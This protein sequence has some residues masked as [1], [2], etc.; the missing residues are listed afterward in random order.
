VESTEPVNET[1][2]P[3][4]SDARTRWFA[5]APVTDG[6]VTAAGVSTA[7]LEG[8]A[9]PPIVL[10]HGQGGFG[11]MFLP[12]LEDLV[13]TN[14]VVVPDLPGLGASTVAEGAVNGERVMRWL[15]ELIDQTCTTPPVIVGH[16][17]GGSIAAR[18]AASPERRLSRLVLADAGGLAGRVRPAPG[19]LVALIRFSIR[20]TPRK[21]DRFSR[22]LLFDHERT[23]QRMGP[24]RRNLFQTYMI[25]LARTPSVKRTNRALLRELGFP[26]I[27]PEE[28]ERIQVPTTLIWGR[29]D[30]V[31]PLAGAQEASRRYGWPLHVIDKAGHVPA[32]EQPAAFL[33]A[34][35]R[36]MT[37]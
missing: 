17:L 24:G 31:M 14:H 23:F 15:D 22:R 27:P 29:H 16:S 11:G 26:A 13:D 36:A 32:M 33:T 4:T 21:A 2:G 20:P 3:T 7:V 6:R 19:V 35:R 18:Y 37:A 12:M 34:L 10:L 28:L 1:I 25:E 8:G 30:P 9:G 5:G